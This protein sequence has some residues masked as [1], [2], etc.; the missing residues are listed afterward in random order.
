MAPLALDC[1]CENMSR[2]YNYSTEQFTDLSGVDI[3]VKD[4]G[5]A[6]GLKFLDRAV[7]IGQTKY[8]SKIIGNFISQIS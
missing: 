5:S 3:H 8:F 7:H 6:D 4:F 2:Y 1:W